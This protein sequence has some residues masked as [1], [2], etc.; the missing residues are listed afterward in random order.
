MCGH[1]GWRRAS[2]SAQMLVSLGQ[3]QGDAIS[4][5]QIFCDGA[6]KSN[7]QDPVQVACGAAHTVLVSNDGY[8]FWSWGR[9]STG[10]LG[11]GKTLDC[12]P[13]T[14]VLWGTYRGFQARTAKHC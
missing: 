4:P 9:G 12:F 5:L 13:P 7:F 3:M 1:G 2:V 8:K 11:N 6:N 10:V 14:V